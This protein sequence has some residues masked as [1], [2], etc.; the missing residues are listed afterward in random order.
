MAK[1][2]LCSQSS[3]YRTHAAGSNGTPPPPPLGPSLFPLGPK[4]CSSCSISSSIY[5]SQDVM[6]VCRSGWTYAVQ[7]VCDTWWENYVTNTPVETVSCT[8]CR[9]KCDRKMP[10]QQQQEHVQ[11]GTAV[12]CSKPDEHLNSK[13]GKSHCMQVTVWQKTPAQQQHHVQ[14]PGFAVASSKPDGSPIL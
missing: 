14:H 7:V 5:S 8:V 9:V 3:T 11:L 12:N 4:L 2:C 10:V 13:Q 1:P 6:Q